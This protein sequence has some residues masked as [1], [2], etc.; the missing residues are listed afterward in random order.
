MIFSKALFDAAQAS[1]VL[2]SDQRF[3]LKSFPADP[4]RSLHGTFEAMYS[5]TGCPLMP[6]P[7][8]RTASG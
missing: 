3:A 6:A 5:D 4:P 2:T 8:A 7:S 1:L